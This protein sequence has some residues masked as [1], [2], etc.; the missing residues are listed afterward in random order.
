MFIFSVQLVSSIS[1]PFFKSDISVLKIVN[2]GIPVLPVLIIF[3][4]EISALEK[5]TGIED[6]N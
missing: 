3:N 2:T 4:T 5:G 6:T 1:V